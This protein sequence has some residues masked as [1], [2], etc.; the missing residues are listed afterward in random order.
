MYA[1]NF[2]GIPIVRH[3]FHRDCC[4]R[5][6][7]KPAS[8]AGCEL[9]GLLRERLVLEL[10]TSALA[11]DARR[12]IIARLVR[13]L[14]PKAIVVA[15]YMPP[16]ASAATCAADVGLASS[17]ARDPPAAAAWLPP[18]RTRARPTPGRG[19]AAGRLLRPPALLNRSPDGTWRC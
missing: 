16:S 13:T 19:R 2:I 12:Q 5:Q 10:P 9:C 17:A 14:A 8:C 7:G 6:T 15:T 11:D 18:L 4:R 3:K 1:I